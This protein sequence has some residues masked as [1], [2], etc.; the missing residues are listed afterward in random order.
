[1]RGVNKVILVGVLGSDPELKTFGDGNSIAQVSIATSESWTDK[2]T[3]ERKEITEWSRLVFNGKLAEIAQKYLKKG[4]KIYVEGS[5]RTRKWQDKNSG[6]DRYATEIRV[7]DMQ[8]LDS[9]P[10]DG[11]QQRQAA[12]QQRPAAQAQYQAADLDDAL[13]F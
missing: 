10:A 6:E 1:M 4:S 13:P 9:K 5:L 12:P 3:G 7:S 11:G 2:N 8:M